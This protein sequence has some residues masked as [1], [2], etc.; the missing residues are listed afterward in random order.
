MILLYIIWI[1]HYILKHSSFFYTV[2]FGLTSYFD[3]TKKYFVWIFAF[4][5]H[6]NTLLRTN[7]DRRSW[8]AMIHDE[9]TRH[10][11]E[12]DKIKT[13]EFILIDT[14]LY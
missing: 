9:G 2:I 1:G 13:G 5:S 14:F 3:S 7:K 11:D 12:K 10:I 6:K 8:R 4:N